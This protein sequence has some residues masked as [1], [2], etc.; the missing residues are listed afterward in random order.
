MGPEDLQ[1]ILEGFRAPDEDPNVLVGMSH[2]DDAGAYR[3]SADTALVQTVDFFTP[4]LDDP[5]QYGQVAAANALSDLYAMGARPL[6]ALALL[7]FPVG[8]LPDATVRAILQGGADKIR[9][10]GAVILGGHTVDDPEPKFGYAVTGIA[11]PDGL[12]TKAGARP[13]DVL[14]LT[15]PIGVGV[16]TTAMKQEPLPAA[17]LAEVTETMAALNTLGLRLAQ[18]GVRAATD[19]TGFGLLGHAAEMARESGVALNIAASRVPTLEAAWA[20]AE[21]D[22]F[23]G[24][25][26]RNAAYV[27]PVVEFHDAVPELARRLLSDAVTAGGLLIAAPRDAAPAVLEAARECGA[28]RTAVIGE[29][30]AAPSGR[31]LVRP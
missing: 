3:L 6:T 25:S 4:I 21:K 17:L 23:P 20:Y 18:F 8:R 19:V 7:A 5:Y 12:L 9:E 28:L 11:H 15:K 1:R 2:P 31:I 13:G 29:V 27:A 16:L 14:L 30:L 22:F 24:G 10:A 26:R